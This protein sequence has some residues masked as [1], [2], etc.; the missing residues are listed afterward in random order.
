MTLATSP[1]ESP[2]ANRWSSA[3]ATYATSPSRPPSYRH[4][5]RFRQ[6]R[7]PFIGR[8]ATLEHPTKDLVGIGRALVRALRI[9]IVYPCIH[10]DPAIPMVTKEEPILLEELCTK[11][12]GVLI[13]KRCSLSILG[14]RRVLRDHLEDQLR[15]RRKA[16]GHVLLLVSGGVLRPVPFHLRNE[17]IELIEEQRVREQRPPIYYQRRCCRCFGLTPLSSGSRGASRSTS[18]P[19]TS[20]RTRVASLLPKA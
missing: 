20:E 8:A 1:L 14:T 12:V 2:T 9:L 18:T 15:D 5:A 7:S 6:Q 19:R 4:D 10:D 17:F 11:P 3:S 16:L 13:T